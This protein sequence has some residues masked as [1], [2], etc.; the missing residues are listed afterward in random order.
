MRTIVIAATAAGLLVLAGCMRQPKYSYEVSM[1]P[2]PIR[3]TDCRLESDEPYCTFENT[4]QQALVGYPATWGYNS[5]G[6]QLA[7][8]P[9]VSLA[10]TQPGQKRRAQL[11][12]GGEYKTISR[13][14]VCSMDPQ[15]PIMKGQLVKVGTA[16]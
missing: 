9:I 12:L 14:V 8:Y 1:C 11:V 3:I 7:R 16:Q 10:G 5:D 4:A 13:I 15:S 2:E 6:V